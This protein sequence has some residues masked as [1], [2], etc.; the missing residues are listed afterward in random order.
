[1][2]NSIST[3]SSLQSSMLNRLNVQRTTMAL[4]EAGQEL[5]TGRKADIFAD[6]GSRSASDL[7]L[8]GREENT[9]TFMK[10]NDLLGNKLEAMLVSVD[11]ARDQIQSVLEGALVNATRPQNGADVLQRDAMAALDNLV[12][13]LNT[14]FNGDFLFGGLASD[15]P[16]LMRWTQTNPATGVSPEDA[17]TSVF[18]G[19][20][21]DAAGAAAIADQLDLA[22][23]SNDAVDPARDFEA[24]FYQGS[25][26][27]DGTGQPTEQAR[28]WLNIDREVSYGIRANDTAFI[29]AYKG[30][31]MLAVTDV[32]A[33]D[34]DAYATYMGRVVEALSAAQEGMLDVSARIG[35]SQQVVETTQTQLTDLS[36]VQ[37]TQIGAFE[38]VD[39][40]EAATRMQ[41]LELQLEA[42]YQV[43]SRLSALSI[44]NYLR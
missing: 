10:S 41:G 13:T 3:L 27:Q 35:F 5:A 28:A 31:A 12:S 33:M 17:V 40:F 30:L 24:T 18:A 15:V 6:L 36:I 32:S 34:D 44:L 21:V 22:F 7:K 39:P 23:A 43:T 26:A 38:N 42:T 4:Q 25:P 20:P 2:T 14:S 1:M 8:R 37:R 11:A 16:P 19:G 29:E 9:Q